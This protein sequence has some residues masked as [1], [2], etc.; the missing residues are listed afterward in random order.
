M[1]NIRRS[2]LL[3][4]ALIGVMGASLADRSLA[5]SSA[6]QM[7]L[8]TKPGEQAM[9]AP[10]AP[11]GGDDSADLAKKL[12]NPIANLISV[13]FQFNYD[14]GFGPK[15]A[16]RWTLNVQP[17]VPLTLNDDWN[18]IVRTIVP[19]VYQESVAD[20]VDSTFGLGD[21]TQSFFFSPKAPTADGWI[22]GVGPAF[23][24]PTGTDDS[25]SSQKWGAGP[26]VVLLKQEKGFTYGILANH[27]WSYA[28]DSNRTYVNST[29]LQPF[30]SYTWPTATT[31]GLNT[32]SSYDWNGDQWTV[33]INLTFGQVVKLGKQPVQFSIGPRYYAES[34]DGG[35]GW[36]ARFTV[37]LL[38]PKK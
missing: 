16:N 8:T 33:P 19:V 6:D 18:L 21:T 31:I 12:S 2:H 20:G 10:A 23:L 30:F 22:W 4:A 14:E 34:P 35:P 24:W 37:T 36:G 1:K 25:L 15:D 32:E 38:Y 28:G 9:P 27:I 5:Q 17:V 29:F 26:T 13:P 3:A 7:T 11:A